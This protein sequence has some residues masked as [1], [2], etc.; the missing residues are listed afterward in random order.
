MRDPLMKNLTALIA[1]LAQIAVG[2][3]TGNQQTAQAH[4]H[5]DPDPL[6]PQPGDLFREYTWMHA[7]GDAGG[8]LRVGG[9]L[10]YGG[11][12]IPWPQTFDLEHAVRAEIVI[13]KLLCH[14]GTRGLALSVNDHKVLDREGPRYAYYA[15]RVPVS[16]TD[17]L[18]SGEN[19]L[20][21][22]KTPLYDGQMVHG[23]E[24]NWPG[25]MVLIQYRD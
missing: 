10:D 19:T 12:P 13:E 4:W 2:S 24:V 14:E 15:H 6:R 22:G 18:R 25:I 7:S 23:M 20:R 21:T 5:G 8:S 17:V 11:G 1:L 9:R 16:D 3:I